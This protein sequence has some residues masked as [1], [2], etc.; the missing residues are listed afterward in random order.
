MRHCGCDRRMCSGS[1]GLPAL[2]S[3]R[4][5]FLPG[6]V[7]RGDGK[8]HV[9]RSDR[10]TLGPAPATSLDGG[11]APRTVQY[12]FVYTPA[13]RAAARVWLDGLELPGPG[14]KALVARPSI[15]SDPCR[16]L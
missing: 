1:A 3:V 15:L 6:I 9:A 4:V 8:S 10:R 7:S 2:V 16:R 11:C 14:R 13:L 5:P 12:P